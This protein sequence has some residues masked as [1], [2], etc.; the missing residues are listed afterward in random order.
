MDHKE[1]FLQ[2]ATELLGALE[3]ALLT[4]ETNPN[5]SDGIQ[6]VFRVMHTLKG[7]AGMFGFE[8][9]TEFTHHIETIYDI[10]RVGDGVLTEDILTLTL[11]SLDH[12]NRLIEVGDELGDE[13]EIEYN[14]LVAKV[15]VEINQ[16]KGAKPEEVNVDNKKANLTGSNEEACYYISFHP[17]KDILIS[18]N[19]PM[20]LIDE[21]VGLGNA[22]VKPNYSLVPK[23]LEDLNPLECYISWEIILY[24]QGGEALIHDVFIFVED[25]C[26]IEI[27]KISKNDLTIDEGLRKFIDDQ[28]GHISALKIHTYLDENKVVVKDQSSKTE[29]KKN[30]SSEAAAHK[31]SSIRVPS[32]KLDVLMNLVSELVTTQAS[33]TMFAEN[34]SDTKLN[35]IAE[36]IEK[37][38]RQLRDSTFGICLVPIDNILTRV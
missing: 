10:I 22:I 36:G 14:E 5:D 35:E 24:M 11:K 18:G 19:N 4:L 28:T 13:L 21:L 30:V 38:S 31:I 29:K 15:I 7:T 32:D 3:G 27:E 23:N 9:V 16:L 2:E 25:D 6:E 26:D 12:I 8:K 1:I 34:S 20:Y 17:G 37:L 33:L